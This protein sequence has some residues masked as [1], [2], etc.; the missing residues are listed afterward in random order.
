M[1]GEA[2]RALWFLWYTPQNLTEAS[3]PPAPP[4]PRHLPRPDTLDP[5]LYLVLAHH[6]GGDPELHLALAQMVQTL[7]WCHGRPYPSTALTG[8]IDETGRHWIRAT[9]RHW[10]A[11]CP[12]LHRRIID[13][14][15]SAIRPTG[16]VLTRRTD[17]GLRYSLDFALLRRWY[18]AAGVKESRLT[19]PA[20]ENPPFVRHDHDL[21]DVLALSGV[22]GGAMLGAIIR[23]IAWWQGSHQG[24]TPK[25]AGSHRDGGY[26]YVGKTH[27]SWALV[28]NKSKEKRVGVH[29][30][31]TYWRVQHRITAAR[32]AGLIRTHEESE[33]GNLYLR[34]DYDELLHAYMRTTGASS[35]A[36]G[37]LSPAPTI[38]TQLSA[39]VALDVLEA[40]ESAPA[41]ETPV[42]EARRETPVETLAPL[43]K[44]W[45]EVQ[46][47]LTTGARGVDERCNA[48]L[49]RDSL[50]PRDSLDPTAASP[51]PRAEARVGGLGQSRASSN[52]RTSVEASRGP[53]QAPSGRRGLDAASQRLTELTGCHDVRTFDDMASTMRAAG[54]PIPP[55]DIDELHEAYKTDVDD[56]IAYLVGALRAELQGGG[57]AGAL[58][59]L[60]AMIKRRVR[61]GRGF[62]SRPRKSYGG[63][64]PVAETSVI[65]K[66]PQP[67]VV[68]KPA[69]HTEAAQM[70]ADVLDVLREQVTPP[71]FDTWLQDTVGIDLTVDG[72]TVSAP[73]W[74][75]A[76]TVLKRWE[77]HVDD[78]LDAVRPGDAVAVRVVSQAKR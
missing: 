76:D 77:R 27:D 11:T 41:T 69:P 10:Q 73:D 44:P 57:P 18:Y 58:R 37:W 72:L 33:Q 30:F 54:F 34:V 16:L 65:P 32:D 7:A 25:L 28:Y 50:I 66:T 26:H 52:Q 64:R 62:D 29:P 56:L 39:D 8:T 21:C 3:S 49:L 74:L 55:S 68:P 59:S 40:A 20:G 23:Q 12:D 78:A 53:P 48:Y 46:G 42:I 75:T 2:A 24:H 38:G 70:W 31:L 13:R 61:K 67:S 9:A 5:D 15:L 45:R 47:A 63:D 51:P 17:R 14:C 4:D 71:S 19:D 36:D 60:R 1:H 22:K 35:P 6:V 43:A